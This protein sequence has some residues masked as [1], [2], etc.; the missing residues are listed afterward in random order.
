MARQGSNIFNLGAKLNGS[1]YRKPPPLGSNIES[2][3]D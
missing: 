3:F 1:I 2:S